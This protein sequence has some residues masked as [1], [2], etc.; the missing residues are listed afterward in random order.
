M[1]VAAAVLMPLLMFTAP[2]AAAEDCSSERQTCEAVCAYMW[3]FYGPGYN[4]C[5]TDCA[6]QEVYCEY[7]K[8]NAEDPPTPTTDCPKQIDE[9]GLCRMWVFGPCCAASVDEV[10]Q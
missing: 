3:V 7:A 9:A 10:E 4:G 6:T 1:L 8:R 2:P 5:M